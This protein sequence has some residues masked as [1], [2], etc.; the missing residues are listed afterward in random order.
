MC[1][2]AEV[3]GVGSCTRRSSLRTQDRR[4]RGVLSGPR[5]STQ[6]EFITSTD[7]SSSRISSIMPCRNST[8]S[9]LA[10]TPA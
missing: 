9:T 2:A 4:L 8:F 1:A 10:S 6:F 7:W 3:S 5:L